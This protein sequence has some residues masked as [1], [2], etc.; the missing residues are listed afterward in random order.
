MFA[1]SQGS[2]EPKAADAFQ[3]RLSRLFG[4]K[5]LGGAASLM[6]VP[7]GPLA[8]SEAP[9]C[10]ITPLRFMMMSFGFALE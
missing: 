7:G 2:P 5:G 3:S 9:R 1:A 10:A 8:M 4:E 6:P